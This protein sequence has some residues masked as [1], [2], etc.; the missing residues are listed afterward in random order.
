M[1]ASSLE[2]NAKKKIAQQSQQTRRRYFFSAG[3]AG[4]SVTDQ[5]FFCRVAVG[6]TEVR[7]HAVPGNGGSEGVGC[8]YR[9]QRAVGS[10]RLSLPKHAIHISGYRISEAPGI[11]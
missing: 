9:C 10:G 1:R 2:Q 6:R 8:G 5:N 3:N 11:S 7:A 4:G